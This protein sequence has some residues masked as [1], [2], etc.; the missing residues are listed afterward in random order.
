MTALKIKQKI[1]GKYCPGSTTKPC[2]VTVNEW[3]HKIGNLA[4]TFRIEWNIKAKKRLPYLKTVVINMQ[5]LFHIITL[6]YNLISKNFAP[7][8]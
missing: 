6:K 5:V 7:W 1:S 4:K 3:R 8:S 2:Y